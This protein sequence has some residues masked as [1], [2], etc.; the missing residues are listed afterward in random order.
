MVSCIDEYFV[1]FGS[2][3]YVYLKEGKLRLHI[4]NKDDTD[5]PILEKP[6]PR[7]VDSTAWVAYIPIPGKH[8][9]TL[10]IPRS[11]INTA[12][13]RGEDWYHAQT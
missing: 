5:V 9:K 12:I 4:L 10:N 2:I 1:A 11:C 3:A 7:S 8:N 6:S 13:K